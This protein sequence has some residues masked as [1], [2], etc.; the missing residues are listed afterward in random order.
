M[1]IYNLIYFNN[2]NFGLIH[3]F[4]FTPLW[5]KNFYECSLV[6]YLFHYW[7]TSQVLLAHI[8]EI[9]FTIYAI[10]YVKSIFSIMPNYLSI[11]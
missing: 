1:N 3:T 5:S 9:S 11:W 10:H 4:F 8:N 7:K 6:Y 2:M